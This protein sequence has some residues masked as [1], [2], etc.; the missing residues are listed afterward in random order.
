MPNGSIYDSLISR[1]LV[2]FSCNACEFMYVYVH[3]W[4]CP[5]FMYSNEFDVNAGS[6]NCKGLSISGGCSLA[7]FGVFQK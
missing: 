7:G 6:D 1:V 4:M 3:V 5:E 2:S